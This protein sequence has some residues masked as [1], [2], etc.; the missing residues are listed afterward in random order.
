MKN[1]NINKG[2]KTYSIND[3]ENTVI[4]VKTTDFSIIDRLTKVQEHIGDIVTE[5]QS[6]KKNAAAEEYLAAL[7]K[8]DKKVKAELDEV[9]DSPVS[10]AVFGNMNSLSFAGGQPVALN[11]LEAIIPE[12]S[13]DLEDEQKAS[14]E[15]I[16]KYTAQVKQFK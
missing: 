2:Y 15:K 14:A 10:A 7:D 6:I 3:D 5:M 4:T 1:L 11:F 16:E 12:I 9:F 8:A 13:A